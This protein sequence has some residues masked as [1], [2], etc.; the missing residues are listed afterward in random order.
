MNRTQNAPRPA[1]ERGSI[2]VLTLVISLVIV[3]TLAAAVT[4][5]TTQSRNAQFALDYTG[6]LALAEGTTEA[7]Q[8]RMLDEVANFRPPT[9]SGFIAISGLNYPYTATPLGAPVNRVSP[10][11]FNMAIQTYRITATATVGTASTTVHRVVD[12]TMTPLFQYMIFYEND[13][14]ILPGPSMMLSGRVHSNSDIYLSCGGT[15]TVDTEHFRATG[16]F[17]RKRKDDNSEGTGTVNFKVKGTTDYQP[18]TNATDSEHPDWINMAID[19][20]Q[21]SVQDGDHGVKE[22]T[23]PAIGTIK[24]FD[25]V[26]AEKG[27]YHKNADLVV[28]NNQAY[29][30]SGN[31]LPL[32]AGTIVEKSMY[33]AREGKPIKVTEID[34]GRLNASGAFPANGLIYAYRTDSSSSK[35]NGIRLANAKEVLKPMTLASQD[36]VYLKGDFNTVNKKGVAVMSDAVNL[37]SNA[38]NDSK[39]PNT[40]PVATATKYNVAM[41]TGNVPTPDGGGSYSGGFE[42]LPRF[43]ENWT[44]V[45]ATI[46]GAFINI[47]ESEIAK[48]KW[49]YGGDKYT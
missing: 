48:S 27:Y 16:D 5:T 29:D 38:W 32:P 30:R 11:G 21:G 12:L 14:E 44:N 39:K 17:L 31:L 25:P 23:T 26:T 13:L 42:N 7:A 2:L 43:H 22:V 28:V 18:M 4:T 1:G 47:F 19:T 34:I 6:A 46:R 35:P 33:D 9:L 15:L 36:P 40:L 41:V 49:V 3:L 24:A 8:K 37:L 10:D 20:W 45:K